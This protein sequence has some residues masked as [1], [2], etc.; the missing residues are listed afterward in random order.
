MLV[1]IVAKICFVN[2]WSFLK[3]GAVKQCVD[4][5]DIQKVF[6]AAKNTSMY[7]DTCKIGLDTDENEPST[8]RA[9]IFSSPEV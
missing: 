9:Y 7:Y 8:V 2:I 6:N 3:F 4:L 1:K 5:V